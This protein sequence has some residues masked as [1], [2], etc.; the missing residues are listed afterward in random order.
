MASNRTYRTSISVV[1]PGGSEHDVRLKVSYSYT[2]GTPERGNF[3]PPDRYDPGSA[4]EADITEVHVMSTNA[5]G[6]TEEV[7]APWLVDLLDDD[8]DFKAKLIEDAADWDIADHDAM[9]EAR[10]QERADD[11]LIER[12]GLQ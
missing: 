9:V 10:A 3:G 5:K 4:A 11:R 12:M 7:A 2:P 8:E 6:V 1:L